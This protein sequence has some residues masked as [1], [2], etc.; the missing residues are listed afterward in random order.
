[1]PGLRPTVTIAEPARRASRTFVSASCTMRY[2]VSRR[3][4]D[5]LGWTVALEAQR[6]RHAGRLDL[7]DRAESRS[8]GSGADV[9]SPF[10]SPSSRSTPSIRRISC[11]A[12]RLVA[13]IASSDFLPRP[14]SCRS[15]ARRRRPAP[16]SRPSSARRRRAAPA[17]CEAARRRPPG[18]PSV[19]ARLRATRRAPRGSRGTSGESPCSRRTSTPR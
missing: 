17:R 1:M 14:G 15:R 3:R 10:A 6:H 19:H 11:S 13:S 5:E 18:A 7:R 8:A 9:S 4:G 16:R 2:P 12:S